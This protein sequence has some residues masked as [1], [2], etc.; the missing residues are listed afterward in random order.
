MYDVKQSTSLPLAIFV[1]DANGDGV[2]GKVD[3]DW[4]KRISKNGGAFAA[5]T[6]TITEMENGW[7]SF[8]LSTTHS[9]TLGILSMSFIAT[10]VKR[11][12][13]QFRVE[14][15][16]ADDLS[17]RIPAALSAGGNMKADV[18]SLGGVVQSLTDLK[19][20]AD[21]GY[22]PATNKVQGVVLVDTLT[23]YT[24]NTPQTGDNYARI[25]A[26][27]A[28]LTALGDVRIAN[29]DATVS[30]RA[31]PTNITAGTITTVTNL[32][33]APTNGDLTATMKTSV[34]TAAT[35]SLAA[36][37]TSSA[38]LVLDIWAATTRI[39]TAGTNI[40][41]AKGTGVTGFNDLSAAQVNA[42]VVDALAVDTY[43][44]P[45]QGAPAATT[46][47]AAKINYLFKAWR[48]RFTQTASQY[49]LYA[50]NG[51]TI[52]Q[53]ATAS[54]DTITFDRGEISSGP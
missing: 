52:D 36:F 27:G 24:G 26:G 14:A 5:M 28:G 53:K 13:L 39:L 3:G 20:F 35:A 25:G 32:T 23:A 50:D 40:V 1:F 44:E 12:N 6:V 8:T 16:L 45:G 2:T 37:F 10:G 48:N 41:L 51:T 22:D 17:A 43:A 15:N 19:D 31:T 33:N 47:L 54:D 11:V 34:Q 18:L 4:T 21:D 49:S 9:D 42:E 7:Y 30:S 38:Q 46:T 29:L